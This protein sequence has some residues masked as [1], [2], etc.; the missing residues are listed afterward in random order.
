MNS[1]SVKKITIRLKEQVLSKGNEMFY[2]VL[3]NNVKSNV[4]YIINLLLP[5]PFK[6]Y[7]S[8]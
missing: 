8:T 2:G 5:I 6:Y 4:T 3:Y 7:C 1:G